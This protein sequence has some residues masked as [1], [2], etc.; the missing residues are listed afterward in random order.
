MNQSTAI[1]FFGVPERDVDTLIGSLIEAPHE[2]PHRPV[3]WF[4]FGTDMNLLGALTQCWGEAIELI[5]V[6]ASSWNLNVRDAALQILTNEQQAL[7]S[8]IW[9]H[10]P[11]ADCDPPFNTVPSV[12]PIA[13]FSNNEACAR[14]RA[15]LEQWYIEPRNSAT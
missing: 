11:D 5:I 4:A 3:R 12:I 8:V 9:V 14:V 7:A 13:S 15:I 10:G 6:G 2:A 1:V